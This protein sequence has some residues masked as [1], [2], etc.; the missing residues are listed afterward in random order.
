MINKKSMTRVA[1]LA[2]GVLL[3]GVSVSSSYAQSVSAGTSSAKGV[4]AQAN[5]AARLS[6][7]ITKSD[8]AITARIDVLNKLNTRVQAMKNVSS[9]EKTNILNDVQ[10]NISGLTALKSKIDADTDAKTALADEKNITGSFR[11][12]ALIVPQASILASADRVDTIVGMMTDV[13]VKLQTRLAAAQSAGKDVSSLQTSLSDYNAKIADAKSQAATAQSSISSLVP[14]KGDKVK[15]A[16]NTAEL[17]AAR[18]NI[19]TATQD[20]KT[21]RQDVKKITQGLKALSP[22]T[23][24]NVSAS[25]TISQ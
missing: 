12:Y 13:S 15:L 17:K 9:T 19:K 22:Q 11:I 21:A 16:S 20:I 6:K 8:A 23:L 24:K 1:S 5:S 14:D 18:A 25:T 2:I 4:K 3:V 10:T 7:I